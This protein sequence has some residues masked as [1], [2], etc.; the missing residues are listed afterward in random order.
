MSVS[1]VVFTQGNV[2]VEDNY[3][4][5]GSANPATDK[6][7]LE[8]SYV[9]G[10]SSAADTA[11]RHGQYFCTRYCT[12]A[13]DKRVCS[14]SL[15][16]LVFRCLAHDHARRDTWPGDSFTTDPRCLWSYLEWIGAVTRP[17]PDRE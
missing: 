3:D 16:H 11:D 13:V 5:A 7:E 12:A 2:D 1:R 8:R 14:T 10:T 15:Y 9:A 6:S 4:A 17:P